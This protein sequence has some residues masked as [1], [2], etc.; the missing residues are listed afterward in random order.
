MVSYEFPRPIAT[1]DV[2]LF[3]VI[4]GQVTEPA[5]RASPRDEASV[6]VV[7]VPRRAE[8]FPGAPAIPGGYLR[9]GEDADLAAAA[10]RVL[11]EKCGLREV[12]LEQLFTYSGATRDPR[13][14]S[15]TTAYY[16]LVPHELLRGAA[17]DLVLRPAD[18]ASGLPFDH[19]RIVADG[20]RR[21]RGKA[22]YTTLPTN[23]LPPRFTLSQLEEVYE[24]VLGRKVH[25]SSFRRKM[26]ELEVRV[27][28]EATPFLQKTEQSRRGKFRPAVMYRKATAELVSFPQYF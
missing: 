2:V 4:G 26:G 8:P 12:F 7:L 22:T 5:D 23:L 11:R 6:Q 21:L 16:A 10:A 3:T 13:D 19:D 17:A 1:V 15:L 9:I 24:A 27:G 14:W 18:R 28:A 25:T 20:L